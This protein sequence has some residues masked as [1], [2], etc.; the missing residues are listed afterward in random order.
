[1]YTTGA[2]NTPPKKKHSSSLTPYAE[3][4]PGL[5]TPLLMQGPKPPTKREEEEK[6]N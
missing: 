4:Q 5:Q 6:K 3:P 1:M 2:S